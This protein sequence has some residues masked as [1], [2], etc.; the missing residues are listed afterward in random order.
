MTQPAAP[1]NRLRGGCQVAAAALLVMA[2][3]GHA[4]AAPPA[5]VIVTLKADA[6]LLREQ[7]LSVRQ[8][9]A[10]VAAVS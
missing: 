9:P 3:A 2:M 7:A 8:S 1:R 4:W 5:R 10:T 6:P